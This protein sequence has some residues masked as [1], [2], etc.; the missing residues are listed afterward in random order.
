VPYTGLHVRGNAD[1]I[2]TLIDMG[3]T[4]ETV[5]VTVLF[6]WMMAVTIIGMSRYFYFWLP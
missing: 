3:G 2:Y 1:A 4:P 5:A 6:L